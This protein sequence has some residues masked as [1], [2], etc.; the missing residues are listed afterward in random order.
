LGASTGNSITLALGVYAGSTLSDLSPVAVGSYSVTFYAQAGAT[1]QIAVASPVGSATDFNLWLQG[2]PPPPAIDE[3]N[4]VRLP[5]GRYRIRVVGVRGQ[6]FVLQGSSNNHT[7]ETIL[8][9]TL[10]AD[11]VD[12]VDNQAA[13]FPQR[14]YRVLPLEALLISQPPLQVANAVSPEPVRIANFGVTSDGRFWLRVTGTTGQPFRIQTSTDLQN[15]SEL[16]NSVITG[17]TMDFADGD[18]TSNE[19]RFYRILPP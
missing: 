16:T 9:E 14:L 13:R 7:W 15:W 11:Y 10:Q 8:I 2:P 1:Y 17:G 19:A 4:T 18:A 5:D 6:S 12:I 3:L